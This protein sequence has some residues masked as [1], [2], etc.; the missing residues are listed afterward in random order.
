MISPLS[1]PASSEILKNLSKQSEDL[2]KSQERLSSGSKFAASADDAGASAVSVNMEGALHRL[3]ATETVLTNTNSYVEIQADA[4]RRVGEVLQRIEE[5][6]TLK[7][8]KTK[9]ETDK[10]AYDSELFELYT[11]I[12]KIGEEKYNGIR[13]FSPEAEEDFL[14]LDSNAI[15]KGTFPLVR[16]PLGGRSS[17]TTEPDPLDVVFL[18]DLTRSMQPTIDTLK[19]NISKFFSSL[20]SSVKSC[21]A[22]VLGFRDFD[23]N[24]RPPFVDMGDFV[25]IPAGIT[26]LQSRLADPRFQADGTGNNDVPEGLEDAIDLAVGQTLWSTSPNLKKMIVAFTDA[27][28]K[29]PQTSRG[30]EGDVAA[31][32]RSSG[33]DL[34]VFGAPTPKTKNFTNEAG[35]RFIPYTPDPSEITKTLGEIAEK[36]PVTVRAARSLTLEQVAM[37]LAKK[38]AEQSVVSV[39][40]DSAAVMKFNL[41]RAVSRIRDTDV[42]AET[43]ALIR[44]RVL[45]DSG[46]QMLAKANDSMKIIVDMIESTRLS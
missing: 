46:V 4:L 38:G 29:D 12:G 27:D 37:Y 34:T 13:L 18:I 44:K 45:V 10:S 2:Q 14:Q 11:E 31:R 15:D 35:G 8:D 33:V 25:D 43:G 9:T 7:L 28:T 16:P 32:V 42:A 20:P 26:T 30:T 41:E 22:K 17:S 36:A 3:E 1:N 21:R 39:L 23:F 5:I 6:K 24:L 19:G 40:K